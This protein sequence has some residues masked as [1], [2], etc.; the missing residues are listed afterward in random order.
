MRGLALIAIIAVS[1]LA[2]AAPPR[3]VLPVMSDAEIRTELAPGQTVEARVNGDMN[4]DGDIDTA[5]IVAGADS[6]DLHVFLSAR[7]EYD[8]FRERAGSFSLEPYALGPADLSVKNGVLI[9]SDLTGG[10]SALATT[11]RFRGEKGMPKMRLIGL[12][13]KAYSRTWAHDGAEMSWNLLT[14]DVIAAQLKLV[15]S[16][17]NA[18]YEKAGAKRSR[19]PVA[20]IF[21][22]DTPNAED[23]LN[24]ATK[25]R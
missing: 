9:V 19:R 1:G 4:G 12:D 7:G 5:F 2:H 16:G 24:A 20:P 17:E 8:M 22:E 3:P 25:G 6:R 21:M 15:G 10:T 11:Y 18:T 23:E 13:A 14:G